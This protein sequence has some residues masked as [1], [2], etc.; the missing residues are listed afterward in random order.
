MVMC[1]QDDLVFRRY[2]ACPVHLA[3]KTFY[4]NNESCLKLAQVDRQMVEKMKE[5]SG[6]NERY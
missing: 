4:E 2:R 5:S 6:L 1:I 3:W